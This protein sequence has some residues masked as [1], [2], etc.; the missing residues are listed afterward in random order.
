VR[1]KLERLTEIIAAPEDTSET[2]CVCLESLINLEVIEVSGKKKAHESIF[3]K[4]KGC[5][6]KFHDAC[7]TQW[8]HSKLSKK[9]CPYCRQEA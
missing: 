2:C 3:R 5:S 6:H 7:I 8:Y 4:M 9:G 1:K